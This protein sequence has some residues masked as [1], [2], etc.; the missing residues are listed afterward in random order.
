MEI[1]YTGPDPKEAAG[2]SRNNGQERP[3]VDDDIEDLQEDD[4]EGTSGREAP[5]EEL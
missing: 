3:D 4:S 2:W 5:N 1:N